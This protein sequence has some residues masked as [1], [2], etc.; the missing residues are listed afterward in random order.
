MLPPGVERLG[1]F[2]QA[3]EPLV[4]TGPPPFVTV[5]TLNLLDRSR[6]LV[7]VEAKDRALR[8]QFRE[9]LI[10]QLHSYSTECNSRWFLVVDPEKTSVYRTADRQ[11][12]ASLS[13]GEIVNDEI[14][15]QLGVVGE[16]TL[17]LAVDKWLHD[18]PSLRRFADRYPDLQE[19][20]TDVSSVSIL[21][22]G[23]DLARESRST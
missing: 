23:E 19:F 16:Q 17:L 5:V 21:R 18:R 13:T 3:L 22:T 11:P 7:V 4:K 15:S 2:L 14:G 12:V 1:P 6:P 8:P 10:Q 20:V 9:P